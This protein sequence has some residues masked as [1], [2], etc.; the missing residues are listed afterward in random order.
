VTRSR[1]IRAPNLNELFQAGTSR[2][3]TLTD[4]FT[5][6]QGVTFREQT[7]GNTALTPEKADST[8]V[9][10][11]L[12]PRFLSGFTFSADGFLIELKDAIGQFY[13][14]DIINRCYEGRTSFCAAYGPDPT[15]E[16]EL[17]FRASP[18][19]FS[20]VTVRGIDFDATYRLPLDRV[21]AGS[22]GNMSLRA[23]ATRY[24]D[25]VVNTGVNIPVNTVGQNGGGGTPK[26]IYRFS[27][28]YDDP[29]FSVTGVA[30]GVSSGSYANN[31]IE[32]T[33]NCPV[34][35]PAAIVSQFQTIDNN[36]ISG[37][38]YADLNLTAKID[39]AGG[40]K[41]EVFLNVT[42]LFNRDPILLPEG[43]LSANSTFSD[44]LGRAFRV[45]VRLRT[46]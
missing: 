4:P 26:W 33:T 14:Q 9:G 41:G 7:T 32:C 18:F 46:R 13:A 3:N 43:G 35:R 25:N 22:N 30:R 6:R 37:V 42:N 34:D 20:K 11:I 24:I 39:M 27:A 36:H 28:T 29:G 17:F 21:F 5:G 12:S 44:L 10:V 1:D 23:L 2:T 45:G 31:L 40:A 15:G 16:R 8:S 38:F 19:N